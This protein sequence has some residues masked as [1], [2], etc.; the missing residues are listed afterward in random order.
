MLGKLEEL[1]IGCAL[2]VVTGVLG[3]GLCIIPARAPLRRVYAR[4]LGGT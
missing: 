2:V 4:R 1:L 3:V